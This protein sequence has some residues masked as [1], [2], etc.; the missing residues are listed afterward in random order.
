MFQR[1][2]SAALWKERETEAR[3]CR[4][5]LPSWVSGEMWV[6]IWLRVSGRVRAL[7]IGLREKTPGWEAFED[8]EGGSALMS[9]LCFLTEG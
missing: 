8:A 9:V 4:V 5:L 1:V 7:A 2:R 6:I 3:A